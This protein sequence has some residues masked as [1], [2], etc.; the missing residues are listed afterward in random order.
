MSSYSHWNLKKLNWELY[1]DLINQNISE[2]PIKI[3]TEIQLTQTQINSIITQLS[4]IILDAANKTVGKTNSS[5]KRKLV[6]W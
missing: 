6:P 1:Y 3:D 2:N 4:N 5:H